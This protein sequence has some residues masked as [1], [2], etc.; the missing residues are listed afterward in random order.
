MDDYDVRTAII[1]EPVATRQA[2]GQ[3]VDVETPTWESR[4]L[5]VFLDRSVC[6]Y[7]YIY[8][9]Y[10][11][12]THTIHIYIYVYYVCIYIFVTYPSFCKVLM[13]I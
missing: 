10:S 7:M 4:D 11:H 8:I 13:G 1:Q 3:V 6:V 12:V 5:D 9:L 2:V